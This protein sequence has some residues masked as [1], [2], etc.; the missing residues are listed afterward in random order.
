MLVKPAKARKKRT[1]LGL[2]H[3]KTLTETTR[4]IFLD[5][6][7]LACLFVDRSHFSLFYLVPHDSGDRINWYGDC[8]IYKS[9]A[10]TYY[11]YP[12]PSTA[13]PHHHENQQS[14]KNTLYKIYTKIEILSCA[15]EV[16]V[17][18]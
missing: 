17:K 8:K 12:P 6:D 15:A 7:W 13:Q 16:A 14:C 11:I 3:K 5:P 9:S 18:N 10:T 1:L 2:F 4:S